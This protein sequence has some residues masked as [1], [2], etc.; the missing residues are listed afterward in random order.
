L[1]HY[2]LPAKDFPTLQLPLNFTYSASNDTDQTCE[3]LPLVFN[4]F[5]T[6]FFL[7]ANFYNGCKSKQLTTNNTRPGLQ[8]KLMLEMN[9][10]GFIGSPK[11][12]VEVSNA[13]C[14]IELPT[15]V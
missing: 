5:L 3:F 15:N 1:G 13:A 8:F 2:T 4:F 7:G 10:M 14:P 6:H 9:I 12:A 11:T